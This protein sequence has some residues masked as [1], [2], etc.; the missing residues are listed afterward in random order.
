[1]FILKQAKKTSFLLAANSTTPR[2]LTP[3]N[4]VD[5]IMMPHGLTIFSHV[6][7]MIS[8]HKATVERTEPNSEPIN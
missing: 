5:R 8:K 4:H 3:F 2:V 1:M 6:D 7:R